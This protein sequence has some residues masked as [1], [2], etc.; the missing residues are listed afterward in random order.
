MSTP[1]LDPDIDQ[2][3][4]ATTPSPG[5]GCR[6]QGLVFRVQEARYPRPCG[7]APEHLRLRRLVTR[8]KGQVGVEVSSTAWK[9]WCLMH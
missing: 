1:A 9:P 5:C 2:G 7:N 3:R 6:V 8:G 4:T